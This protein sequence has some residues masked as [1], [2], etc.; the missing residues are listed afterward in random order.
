VRFDKQSGLEYF[1]VMS[2]FGRAR[3]YSEG[4]NGGG[5]ALDRKFGEV[6]ADSNL[7]HR[8]MKDM[9]L[10]G[11]RVPAVD[12]RGRETEVVQTPD[13]WAVV[14]GDGMPHKPDNILWILAMVARW[15]ELFRK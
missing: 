14:G 11:Q 9:I 15:Q 12:R 6:A 4:L 13:G 8:T 7:M 1:K 5:E 10:W 2:L 3:E